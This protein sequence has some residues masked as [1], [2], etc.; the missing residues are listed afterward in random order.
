MLSDAVTNAIV[1]L[2]IA[3]I[4][5]LAPAVAQAQDADEGGSDLLFLDYVCGEKYAD[6]PSLSECL[7]RQN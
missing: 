7:W 4:A 6:T 3:T 5:L 1:A 2:S